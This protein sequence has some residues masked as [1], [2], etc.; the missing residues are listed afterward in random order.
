LPWFTDLG[1][2][3]HV[4][5]G[6]SREV[7]AEPRAQIRDTGAGEDCVR[8][9]CFD[10]RREVARTPDCGAFPRVHGRVQV[11]RGRSPFS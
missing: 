4:G 10:A 7:H 9:G 6:F 2:E 11:G 8:A 5:A 1:G 3:L